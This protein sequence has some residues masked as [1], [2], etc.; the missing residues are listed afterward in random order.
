MTYSWKYDIFLVIIYLGSLFRLLTFLL[1]IDE[2]KAQRSHVGLLAL[3]GA[4]LVLPKSAPGLAPIK[5]IVIYAEY[6]QH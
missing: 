1:L 6:F 2:K 4:F 3:S 5:R